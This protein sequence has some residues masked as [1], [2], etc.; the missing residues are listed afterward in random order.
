M[1][2]FELFNQRSLEINDRRVF[3]S[4]AARVFR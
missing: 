4:F 3:Q 1:A 2:A